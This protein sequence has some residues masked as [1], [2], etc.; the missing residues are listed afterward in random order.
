[1]DIP[2]VGAG[3]VQ[4]MWTAGAAACV[5]LAAWAVRRVWR[6][7]GNVIAA[8]RRLDAF[9]TLQKADRKAI[10]DRLDKLEKAHFAVEASLREMPDRIYERFDERFRDLNKQIFE[11]MLKG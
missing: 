2:E 9:E 1:M 5:A 8:F 3:P 7:G 11:L 4:A 6:F 10:E